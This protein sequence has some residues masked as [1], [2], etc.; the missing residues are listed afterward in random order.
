VWHCPEPIHFMAL[1]DR[2]W[3]NGERVNHI[4]ANRRRLACPHNW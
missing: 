1:M 3:N 4:A 2:C